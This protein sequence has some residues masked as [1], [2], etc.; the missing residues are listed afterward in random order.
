MFN[1][2]SAIV[3]K[4]QSKKRFYYK[5]LVNSGIIKPR[6]GVLRLIDESPM[7]TYQ[8]KRILMM[9]P[10]LLFMAHFILFRKY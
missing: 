4:L 2:S 7:P 8:Q 5:E 1:I 10:F 3:S 9:K 6:E